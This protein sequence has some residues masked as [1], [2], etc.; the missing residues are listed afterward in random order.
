MA[1][2]Y[3]G[4]IGDGGFL[5]FTVTVPAAGKYRAAVNYANATGRIKLKL[6]AD[7]GFVEFDHLDLSTYP[8][9]AYAAESANLVANPGF[10]ADPAGSQTITNWSSWS[11]AD[12][13][14]VENDG[15]FGARRATHHRGT[16]YLV[17]THQT[18]TGLPNGTYTLTADMLGDHGGSFLSAKAYGPVP[19]AAGVLVA[20]SRDQ[21]HVVDRA[22]AVT[23]RLRL[24]ARVDRLL[25]DGR[26]LVHAIG[27][28]HLTTIDVPTPL[29]SD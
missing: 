9:P 24:P 16:P 25:P 15:S 20:R 10:E 6:T 19:V 11:D 29:P 5:Q 3:V 27:K 22:G 17:Y 14:Y 13:D 7:T 21:L 18:V 12:A 26:S 8:Q 1:R 4:G 2:S 28:G 23:A